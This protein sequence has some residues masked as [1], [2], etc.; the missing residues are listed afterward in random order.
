Y[1]RAEQA[2]YALTQRDKTDVSLSHAGQR[3][4]ITLTRE[5]FDELTGALLSRTVELTRQALAEAEKRGYTQIDQLLLVGGSTRMPQVPARLE[6][7]FGIEPK[8]FEPDE[9]VAKGAAIYGQKLMLDQEIKIRIAAATGVTPDEVEV[10]AAEAPVMAAAQEDIARE[11][12]LQ[13]GAV[14]KQAETT[15]TNVTSRSFGVVAWSTQLQQEVVSNLIRR[16]DPLPATA[17]QR[18]G[19][20]EVSQS[21]ALIRI[22]DNLS[23]EAQ[24]EPPPASRLIGEAE[25]TLP[26]GLP[27]GSPVEITFTLD[28]QGRLHAQATE[29]T[30]GQAVEVAIETELGA[31]PEEIAAA[32]ARA[33]SLVVS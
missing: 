12:G 27:A 13:L 33:R 19:T 24:Y 18:F 3:A 10:A 14:K 5:K 32:E 25:L 30:G 2:K 29:L 6:A 22:V 15:I 21:T 17:S 11:Y 31:S 7:E 20:R 8:L 16:N 26:Y 23:A 1:L 28:E 4:R 9:A